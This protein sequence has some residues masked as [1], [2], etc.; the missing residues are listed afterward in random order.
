[1]KIRGLKLNEKIK[2]I[3]YYYE[4]EFINNLSLLF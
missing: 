3:V 4:N 1:M 2:L